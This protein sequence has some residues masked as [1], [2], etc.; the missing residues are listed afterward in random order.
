MS[1]MDIHKDIEATLGPDAIGHST[2][3]KYLREPQITHDS[4]STSTAIEDDS[5][6]FIDK[7]I[8]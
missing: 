4:G 2:V 5:Q 7:V 3:T 1:V 8:L 6:S